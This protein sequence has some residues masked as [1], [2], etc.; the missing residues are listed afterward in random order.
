MTLWAGDSP[1][2]AIMY[3]RRRRQ[4]LPRCLRV[5]CL[6][7]YV[8]V[9]KPEQQQ[10]KVGDPPPI[11]TICQQGQRN[12]SDIQHWDHKIW[13]SR[14]FI[15]SIFTI[16]EV[17]CLFNEVLFFL[18]KIRIITLIISGSVCSLDIKCICCKLYQRRQKPL[19]THQV[20]WS[21]YHV[22]VLHSC[23]APTRSL[24]PA[25]FFLWVL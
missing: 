10:A 17:I 23:Q 1:C 3:P 11:P 21:L 9:S 7:K 12:Q 24:M 4:A 6:I 2:R 22:Y 13:A 14:S 16:Q 8:K 25:R 19:S 20:N 5:C 18:L 15:L